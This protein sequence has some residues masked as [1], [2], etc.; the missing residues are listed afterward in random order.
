MKRFLKDNLAIV[1]AI[2][3]PLI[4]VIVFAVST[5][6]VNKIVADPRYDFLIA[7]NFYGGANEAF[8]F[9]VVQNTLK[10]SYAYP[11]SIKGGGYQ[12]S[13]ISRLWRVRVPAMTV[14]EISLV[15]PSRG[16]DDEDGKRVPIAIPGVSDLR[17]ISTQPAPDGYV[18]QESY[19]YY[20]GNL[21]RELFSGS[22]G[23]NR[24]TCAIIKDGRAVPVKNLGGD[25]YNYYNP[26][27]IGWIVKNQ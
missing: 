9:D 22:G 23:R 3:L 25:S 6:V 19:D 10:I 24:H 21:M 7:T 2:A 5:S 4:L 16:K 12:N 20:G 8:Y 27:F 18:F 15:P 11:V 14:E 1:A 13:N 17:V 26:H